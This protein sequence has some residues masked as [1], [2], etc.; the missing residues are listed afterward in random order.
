MKIWRVTIRV[1]IKI[2]NE[3]CP[4]DPIGDPAGWAQENASEVVNRALFPSTV[5]S[6]KSGSKI[7]MTKRKSNLT[8]FTYVLKSIVH[9]I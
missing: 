1:T 3:K 6:K 8:I 9:I 7:G 4:L 5:H 2:T